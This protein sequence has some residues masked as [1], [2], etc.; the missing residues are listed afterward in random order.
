LS[1]AEPPQIPNRYGS[2]DTSYLHAEMSN[3]HKLNDS[4]SSQQLIYAKNQNLL[5]MESTLSDLIGNGNGTGK[6]NGSRS[7]F[8]REKYLE[9][10]I[11]SMEKYFDQR[12]VAR[13]Q[14]ALDTKSKDLQLILTHLEQEKIQNERK[15]NL[16]NELKLTMNS[17]V[18]EPTERLI[19]E[20]GELNG[21]ISTKGEQI[22]LLHVKVNE[23]TTVNKSL[24]SENERLTQDKR[25]LRN[26]LKSGDSPVRRLKIKTADMG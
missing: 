23:L 10:R 14:E 24:N 19:S 26:E 18:R 6:A 4:L 12:E 7:P 8:R 9:G 11:E 21:L 25:D 2:N 16:I 1:K 15:N 5:T 17:D 13:L 20:I 22:R 3:S